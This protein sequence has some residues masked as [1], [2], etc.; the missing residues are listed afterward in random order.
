M[1][2][3]RRKPNDVGG[4]SVKRVILLSVAQGVQENYRNLKELW[5]ACSINDLKTCL[6][7]DHKVGNISSGI[8]V[9]FKLV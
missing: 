4:N 3:K 9:R 8:Q 2:R 1:G 6:S 7:C 5:D